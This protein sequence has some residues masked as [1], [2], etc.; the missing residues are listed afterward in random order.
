MRPLL[1][2]SKGKAYR[3]DIL[4]EHGFLGKHK[5]EP[6]PVCT[7]EKIRDA[8]PDVNGLW[9]TRMLSRYLI[10]TRSDNIRNNM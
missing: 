5:R 10:I 3:E 1:T 4:M 7:M 8:F 9:V 6:V 2:T